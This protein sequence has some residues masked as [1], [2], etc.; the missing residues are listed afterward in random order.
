MQTRSFGE[1]EQTAEWQALQDNIGIE[2]T[3]SQ[4]ASDYLQQVGPAPADVAE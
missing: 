4:A 2:A 1:L 3:G